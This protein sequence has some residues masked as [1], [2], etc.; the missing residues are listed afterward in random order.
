MEEDH[1]CAASVH[2]CG[3]VRLVLKTISLVPTFI[4]VSRAHWQ[5]LVWLMGRYIRVLE[6][7]A[8]LG[9]FSSCIL[10]SH[11]DPRTAVMRI[12]RY[13]GVMCDF[14]L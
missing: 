5:E 13:I 10:C 4:C 1:L 12:T 3:K 14:V 11:P 7:A 6:P 8:S 9:Q 2:T